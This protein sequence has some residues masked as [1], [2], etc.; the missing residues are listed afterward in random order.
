PSLLELPAGRIAPPTLDVAL[1]V[2]DA[3]ALART[4]RPHARALARVGA[5]RT[6]LEAITPAARALAEAEAALD[7]VRR[8]LRGRRD[9]RA[10]TEAR[11]LRRDMTAAGRFA[12]RADDDAQY[13]L[14]RVQDGDALDD[15]VG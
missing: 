10:V 9:H 8:A 4:L 14:D 3:L 12:L 5:P 15:L 13:A 11:V 6:A 7:G 1:L 2:Q